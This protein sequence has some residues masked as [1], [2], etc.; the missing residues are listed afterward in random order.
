[1]GHLLKT[2]VAAKQLNITYTRL[3]SLIRYGKVTPPQKDSSGDYQWTA[4]DL[5]AVRKILN[6]PHKGG[7]GRSLKLSRRNTPTRLCMI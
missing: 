7:E 5:A 1:M 3:M 4:D 6:E 2:P